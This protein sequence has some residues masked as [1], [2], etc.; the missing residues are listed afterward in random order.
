[1]L[2]GKLSL[3][4]KLDLKIIGVALLYYFSARVGYFFAF[5]NTTAL[6]AW[7]PSGIAFALIILLGRSSWPGIMIGSLIANVMA[8]WN[9]PSLPAQTIITISSL[10]AIGHTIEAVSGNYLV[11]K[12]IRDDYPFKNA[13]NAFRFLFVT[14]SMCMLGAGIGSLSLFFNNALL[15]EN[16]LR[17]GFS[18]WVGNVVGILLFTPIILASAKKIGFKFSSEKAMEIG[19]FLLLMLGIYLLL[20]VNYLKPTLERALPFLVL[21]FLLWLAFRFELIVAIAGVLIASLFAIYIRLS[22]LVHLPSLILII[23]CCFSR[24]LSG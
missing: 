22:V 6:P 20:Q 23:Q 15:P 24:F 16:L 13:K 21:P 12:W 10:I 11:K 17:T 8:Y 4:Y 5:E 19:I 3:K 2:I 14:M 7:P 1:M 9:N 18:W